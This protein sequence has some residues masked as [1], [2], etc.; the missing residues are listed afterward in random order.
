MAEAILNL[1]VVAHPD[2]EVLGIGAAGAKFSHRGEIVQPIFLCGDVDVRTLRP[3]NEELAADIEKACRIVGF[4]MP[5]LGNFPNI[6]LNT[7]PHLELVQF[8]E[9][10]IERYEPTRIFTHHPADLNDDHNFV[11]RATLA[12]ARLAQRRKD[13]RPIRSLHFMEI[14]SSTDWAFPHVRGAFQ[15]TDYVEIGEF[16]DTKLAALE[17]YRNVMR[18]FPHSR[19]REVVRGLAAVRGGE[20]GLRYAEA[21]QTIFSTQLD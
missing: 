3:T 7:V 13:V 15:P 19:S 16:L 18:P 10:Q 12:A 2:D 14:L 17:S 6:R 5:T 1:V 8:V 20:S 21:F 4:E 9:K 11:S